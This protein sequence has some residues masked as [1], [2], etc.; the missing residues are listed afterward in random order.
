MSQAILTA[1]VDEQDKKDFDAFCASV[2]L[3]TSVA[4]NLYVKTV[5]REHRIPFEISQ[6]QDPFFDENNL[7]IIEKSIKEL[8]AGKGTSHELIEADYE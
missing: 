2:G 8:R 3:N 1:R 7:A 6:P 4:I 5:L